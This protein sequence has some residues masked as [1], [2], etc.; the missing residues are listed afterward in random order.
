MKNK[1][2]LALA[3][4]LLLILPLAACQK[5][6]PAAS[7]PGSPGSLVKG[8]GNVVDVRTPLSGGENGYSLR[9]SGF[10][11]RGTGA[12]KVS[13]VIDESLDREVVLTT[14]DNIV[15]YISVKYNAATGG[16]V[17]ELARRAV[18]SPTEI[19]IT[20][21]GPVRR[22]DV[23][24]AWAFTYNCPGVTD[25][26]GDVNGTAN[27]KLTFGSLNSLSMDVNGASDITLS[28]K[29]DRA[30]LTINGAAN[31]RAFD[32][33]AQTADVGIN[34]AGNCEITAETVLN[35]EINGLGK[36]I[37]GGNPTVSRS[38]H[39]LGTVKAR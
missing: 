29:A 16:I 5:L 39:G 30:E 27:G 17:V 15:E 26:E 8:S 34:G 14:D 1:K 3:L 6:K 22:L 33:A 36:I 18:F 13:L 20:V 7:L 25:F 9:V 23:N 2:W 12:S 10:S 38:V 21:G 19:S 28:G 11:F 31:I 37:Y 4:A 35:A 24:G 32:L